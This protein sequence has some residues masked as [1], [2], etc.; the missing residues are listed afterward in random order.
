MKKFYLLLISFLALPV[1]AQTVDNHIKIDQFGYLPLSQKIA[2]I[3][4]PQS[5]FNAGA[6]FTPG[7]IYHVRKVSDNSSV[8]SGSPVAWNGGATHLQSGDKAW[9][10]DFSGVTAQ[11]TY[12]IYDPTNNV[13]SYNFEISDCVYEEVL[14]QTTRAFYYQRCGVAKA[15]PHAHAGWTDDACHVGAQQ[16]TDCRLYNN[17]SASTSRDLSGGWHDAGDY[18]K[19]VNFIYG[20]VVDMLL[21]YEE[22]PEVWS[23]DFSI[24]ESGN[25]VPDILDEVKFELDWL[26]KMQ[27]ENGS[28]LSVVGGGSG[29][30]PSADANPRRYGPATTS[31]SLS[32]AAMFALAAIQFEAAGQSAYAATLETAAVKAWTWASA[33][34]NVTFHNS[35]ILAAGEQETSTQERTFRKIAAAAYLYALTGNTSYRTAFDTEVTTDREWWY[36]W[37]YP[38][39]FEHSVQDA[40]LYYTKTPGASS[41][42]ATSIRDRYRNAILNNA[43]HYKGFTDKTDAYRAYLSDGNYTWGSNRVKADQANMFLTMN[44]YGFHSGSSEGF[45][46]AA[47]GF[48]HYMHGVNPLA[49]TYLSNMGAFGAENSVTEFYHSWFTDGSSLWDKT[50]T[51]TF[52]PAPGFVP[53]GPN[54]NYKLDDCCAGSCTWTNLCDASSVTPPLAQPIQKSYKDWNTSWPQNSWEVTE[55]SQSYQAAYIRMLSQFSCS[56][57]PLGTKKRMGEI[58]SQ[59]SIFP[60]PTTGDFTVELHLDK[61]TDLEITIYNAIGTTVHYTKEPGVQ[62]TPFTHDVPFKDHPAG[63]YFVHVK[64]GTVKTVERLIKIK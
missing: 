51:S 49:L 14:K 31:A 24:P 56:A 53:G 13:K 50:G 18:N 41:A 2:V 30:P 61:S 9:W 28:V 22:N 29:S 16:D 44:V 40:M 62:G 25:G 19:Y 33:N 38:Y 58:T 12:Y 10:F 5:G 8:F 1:L 63:V 45:R 36:K 52:G 20:P 43:D 48:V 6:A 4:N 37:Y 26:L 35:G 21:A 57:P 15:A 39:P 59:V 11:G 34:T 27:N 54:P 46:N 55:N 7:N 3:S 60:N 42:L 17:T 47:S 23:D 32:A 64:A